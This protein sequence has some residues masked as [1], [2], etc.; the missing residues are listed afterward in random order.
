MIER[1]EYYENFL[2]GIIDHDPITYERGVIASALR[3]GVDG[4]HAGLADRLCNVNG[5]L[6]E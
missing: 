3:S 5:R 1:T 2:N 4:P 6:P